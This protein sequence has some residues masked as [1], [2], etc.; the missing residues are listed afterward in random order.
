M[1]KIMFSGAVKLSNSFR[2]K[3]WAF[4]KSHFQL[5]GW[6]MGLIKWN[7]VIEKVLPNVGSALLLTDSFAQLKG[8]RVKSEPIFIFLGLS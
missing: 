8:F 2:V 3:N 7:L 4:F 1:E 6:V 5:T